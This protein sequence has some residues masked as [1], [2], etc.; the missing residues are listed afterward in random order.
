M[1]FRDLNYVVQ[2][3][4]LLSFS[5]AAERCNVSQPSLSAQIKKL[6]D[7]LGSAIFVRTKRQVHVT[8]FGKNFVQKAIAMLQLQQEVFSMAGEHKNPLEGVVRLGAILTV[9]PYLF[10]QIVLDVQAKAPK[11]Q[12]SLKEGKTEDLLSLLLSDKIDAAIISLPTDDHVFESQHLFTEAFYLAVPQGHEWAAKKQ[13]DEEELHDKNLILLEEGHCLRA[14]ALEVCQ[15]SLAKEN[16]IFTATS[17]ETIR[18]FIAMGAGMTLMPSM[19]RLQGDSLSYIPFKN[20]N[21]AREIGIVWRKSCNNKLQI[22]KLVKL[23]QEIN[24]Q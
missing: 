13:V 20:K 18:H 11:M 12:L 10:P 17:L 16:K 15:L 2:A 19:A 9:A 4:K 3:A 5:K 6:E 8:A 21:F 14:Q 24:L 1:N 23:I 22:E 7:E